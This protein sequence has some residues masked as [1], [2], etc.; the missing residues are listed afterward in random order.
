[1]T[2]SLLSGTALVTAVVAHGLALWSWRRG[3]QAASVAW[4]L[5][6]GFS[7]RLFAAG[8]G[9]L[10]AWDERFHALV[11]KNLIAHPLRPTLYDVALF[12]H[13]HRNWHEAHVWLHKPPLA[14]WLMALSMRGFGIGELALRL[15]SLA[16]STAAIY[17]TFRIGTAWRGR[18]VGWLAAFFQ[19]INAFLILLAAG[20]YATDHVDTAL[21][22]LV[23]LAVLPVA[24]GPQAAWAFALLGVLSGLAV[25][26]KSV[27]GLL[28]L[29]LGPLWHGDLRPR[30]T[31]VGRVLL[32][33]FA[34]LVV[35]G[36][37]WLYTTR[38]FPVEAAWER[39]YNLR[40]LVE[41]LEG[42]AG[43]PLYHLERLPRIYGELIYL[44][45]AWFVY[46]LI[47]GERSR[48]T[49]ALAVWIGVPYLVFSLAASKMPAYVMIAAP[50]VFMV[51]AAFWVRL[52]EFWGGGRWRRLGLGLLL[53]GLMVAPMRILVNDLRLLRPYDRNPAW[54]P[55]LEHLGSR[56]AG[57]PA[58]IFGSPRPI[59]TMFYTSQP[60]YAD[61]PDREVVEAL[62]RQGR[63]VLIYASPSGPSDR[64][65]GVEYLDPGSREE[66]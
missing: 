41:P 39:A 49:L 38:A 55:E 60:A 21:V 63:L 36:P 31:W 56:L 16:L 15:P 59:E 51:Q 30:R 23:A 33:A 5:V 8:D 57:K 50:A 32:A 34:C 18:D 20:W 4:L 43:S 46:R 35:V 28:P 9:F 17:A 2:S 25:L 19:S 47:G 12:P 61:I 22:S 54:V 37:W 62:Q 48:G 53:A 44:P 6:G 14:L 40:H 66:E 24:T 27:P 26:S 11:A 3:S 10:H 64:W 13:D 42:H 7:L 58:A 1:M 29:A 65:P 52:R 45:L